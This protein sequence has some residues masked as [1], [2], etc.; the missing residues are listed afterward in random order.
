VI[1]YDPD[2]GAITNG[3]VNADIA[4]SPSL[5]A[6]GLPIADWGK[7][8]LVDGNNSPRVDPDNGLVSGKGR[9]QLELNSYNPTNCTILVNAGLVD[10]KKQTVVKFLSLRVWP[11]GLWWIFVPVV[12][13]GLVSLW[14]RRRYLKLKNPTV[15]EP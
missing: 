15:G 11:P 6:G 7:S 1:R 4:S 3:S 2:S 14:A 10:E 5:L 12:G 9:L 13:G 8:R